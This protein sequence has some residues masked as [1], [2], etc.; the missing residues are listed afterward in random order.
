M[1]TESSNDPAKSLHPIVG[2]DLTDRWF[3]IVR[4]AGLIAREILDNN[5]HVDFLPLRPGDELSD[6]MLANI[7]PFYLSN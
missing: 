5:Q 6:Y 4:D 1:S 7:A 2:I 3:D